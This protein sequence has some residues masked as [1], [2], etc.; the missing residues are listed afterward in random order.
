[1]GEDAQEFLELS[2]IETIIKKYSEFIQYPIKLWK[3]TTKTV[4]VEDDGK[5]EKED[6][7][8]DESDKETKTVEKT[9][10]EWSVL[11]VNKPLWTRRPS[12]VKD[13]LP[14]RGRDRVRL[15]PVHP[16]QRPVRHV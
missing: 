3:S 15:A 14:R 16:E 5:D 13:E 2:G 10:W 1:M 8:D 9:V 6:K 7:D 12:D 4:E 11:N